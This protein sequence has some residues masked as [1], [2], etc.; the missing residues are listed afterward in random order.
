MENNHCAGVC[1]AGCDDW[2]EQTALVSR[3]AKQKNHLAKWRATMGL[4]PKEPF[5]PYCCVCSPVWYSSQGDYGDGPNPDAKWHDVFSRDFLPIG[6]WEMGAKG[7]L[8][9][10]RTRETDYRPH[11][12]RSEGDRKRKRSG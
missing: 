6:E 7:D 2:A 4:S 11:I 5:G 8:Q 3:D 10:R 12:I 1:E 9:H